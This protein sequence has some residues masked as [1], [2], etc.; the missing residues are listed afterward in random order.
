MEEAVSVAQESNIHVGVADAHNYLGQVK[1]ALHA[2]RE[3]RRLFTDNL[4]LCQE[5]PC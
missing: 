5:I 4:N 1:L 3:A 2:D